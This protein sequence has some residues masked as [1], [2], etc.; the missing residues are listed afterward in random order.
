MADHS[1]STKAIMYALFAN[2]GIALFKTAAS[3]YTGSGSMLAEAIHSYAD[4]GNQLLLFLGLHR[5]KREPDEEHPL[6]YGK[7][8]YFWSFIVALMLFS[9]G[10]LFSVYEG[11]HKLQHP[12]PISQAWVALL[13]LGGSILLEMGSL[14]GAVKE[15]NKV[16]GSRT[17]RRWFRES[18]QA[19]LVVV[20][21]EDV[22]ALA[23]LV[24]AF[25][26]I[27]VAMVTG[28][29]MYDAMGSVAIGIILIIV[30]VSVAIQVK[31]ML[32]GRSA[33]PE[34]QALIYRAIENDDD[35][36]DVFNVITQ[37]HGPD[38]MLSAKVRMKEGLT[39]TQAVK[40]INEL[41]VRLKE[42][43]P[44]L[45]WIFVEPD[46]EDSGV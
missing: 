5:A 20:F 36:Q 46:I 45:R 31:S 27:L 42:E 16:R 11:V 34:V 13:V 23:G 44:Q 1:G 3:I 8:I 14:T 32:I 37:Q 39:I 28:D 7:V 30:A 41:E 22:A 38:V 21:G 26:F 15:I 33:D 19:E 12:E 25:G 9:M 17:L 29:P 18:R 10:G 40:A 35:I 43:W 6:G 4:C 24:V 2:F